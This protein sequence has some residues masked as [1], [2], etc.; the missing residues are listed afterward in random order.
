MGTSRCA[1]APWLRVA[2]ARAHKLFPGAMERV[3][4]DALLAQSREPCALLGALCGGEASAERAET[5]C[6]VLQRLEERG[7]GVRGL[8]EAAHEV[9]KGYLVPLLH[10]SPGGG[11]TRPRVLRAA[12]A[13][14]RSCARLAGPEL[15][16]ALA[17]DALRELP[18][19]PAVELL[20]ATAP[21]LRSLEDAPLLRRL[22][23]A[24]VELALAGDAPPAVGT[25]LL[26]ALAQS[27]EPALRAAWDAL[28]SA[29]LG[30]DDRTGSE[31]LV[32]SALAEKLLPDR[33]GHADLDARLCGRFWRTI[34]AGLSRGQDALTRKRARYLLQKAVQV[35]AELAVDCTCGSQ[36]TK[37]THLPLFLKNIE[38]ELKAAVNYLMWVL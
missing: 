8:A 38:L 6:L 4:A 27:A 30:A 29:G 19:A 1:R 12:S 25:R 26:P 36:D 35:S 2:C 34:Q 18:G 22:A 3:L 10:A 24:A 16:V 14:L 7:V 32:L 21:C 23:R 15:A 37:G 28:G 20:A 11:P 9:A 17:E 13:A 5:L 31:L 33:A